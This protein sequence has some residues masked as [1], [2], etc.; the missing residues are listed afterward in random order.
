MQGLLPSPVGSVVPVPG[1]ELPPV[2]S[3]PV[4]VPAVVPAVAELLAESVP[5]VVGPSAQLGEHLGGGAGSR[6]RK[7]SKGE[8]RWPALQPLA[9]QGGR[10]RDPLRPD[11]VEQVAEGGSN[12]TV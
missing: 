4:V 7:C 12:E 1:S 6:Q 5:A 2:G 8:Q 3:S 11:G 9:D 10:G